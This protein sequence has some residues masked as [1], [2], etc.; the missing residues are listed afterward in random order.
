MED[1]RSLKG[2]L[3]VLLA[4]GVLVL[5]VQSLGR[6][7]LVV[8]CA[9]DAVFAEA[10]L[11]DFEKKT[12]VKVAVKYD[13][14]ATKSLGF[15]EQ[16]TKET[17]RPRCDVFWNNELLGTLELAARGV[18]EPYRGGGWQRI[19]ERFRDAEGRWAGFAARLRMTIHRADRPW[20]DAS[21]AGDL[22][23]FAA[24]K[25]LY[26]TTLTHYTV[27][28]SLWGGER[29]RAWHADT[30]RRGL[31]E[32]NG[33]AAVKEV[34]ATGACDAGWT[35]SDD[36]FEARDAG[37]SVAAEPVR[38]ENGATICIPNTVAI[39]RGTK[40]PDEAELLVDFLLSARTELALAKSKSRQIPLGPLHANDAAQLPPEVRDLLP[41]AAAGTPLTSLLEA[42]NECLGW[43]KSELVR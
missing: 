13:T 12:G 6:E 11:R 18:L 38:M 37:S 5:A 14:E 24:A 35:D 28:W 32:V 17:T 39:I 21:L 22:S 36:Y 34:V 42:R 41:A 4:I 15:V 2:N 40:N 10:V 16:L 20:V 30:R 33:N 26:G 25:P 8:Y 9:H 7:K 3:L 1:T 43:L 19:P 29:L 31:R 23:R 27:L